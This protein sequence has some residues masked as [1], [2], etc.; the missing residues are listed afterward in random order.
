M[1]VIEGGF[2]TTVPEVF[3][4]ITETEELKDYEYAFCI[5]KSKDYLVVSTNMETQELNFLFDQLKMEMIT[6]GEYEI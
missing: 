2:K 5:I 3:A 4:A 6:N 1:K